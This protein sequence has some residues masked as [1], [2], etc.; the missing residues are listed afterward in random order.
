MDP[1][2]SWGERTALRRAHAHVGGSRS[3]QWLVFP[4]V[5]CARCSEFHCRW[6]ISLG[7]G[8][9][10][11][12]LMRYH[13]PR[14]L[15]GGGS[16]ARRASAVLVSVGY[17]LVRGALVSSSERPYLGFFGAWVEFRTHVVRK[18]F[19]ISGGPGV[20]EAVPQLLEYVAYATAV[21][22]LHHT[23]PLLPTCLLSSFSTASPAAGSWIRGTRFSSMH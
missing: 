1:K 4:S 13:S 14:S 2:V 23:L 19:F 22:K 12:K 15:A 7:V 3:L 10:A 9:C 5:A 20:W 16:G 21:P 17:Q 6:Y 18:P 8:R 11:D